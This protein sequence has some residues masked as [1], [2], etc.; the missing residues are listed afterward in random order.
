MRHKS[1]Q[2]SRRGSCA[3]WLGS[4]AVRSTM[5]ASTTNASWHKTA[6][7][8]GTVELAVQ[9]RSGQR[10]SLCLLSSKSGTGK[11]LFAI[12]PHCLLV[13]A[14]Y[15]PYDILCYVPAANEESWPSPIAN[16]FQHELM[17]NECSTME[18]APASLN[19]PMFSIL[20]EDGVAPLVEV[21][22][23]QVHDSA[24]RTHT[25]CTSTRVR[26]PELASSMNDTGG[27]FENIVTSTTDLDLIFLGKSLTRQ[28]D[29]GQGHATGQPC[30]IALPPGFRAAH[31]G[32]STP[33]NRVDFPLVAAKSMYMSC[34][35]GGAPHLSSVK[36]DDNF[37]LFHD[38]LKNK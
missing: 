16:H 36:T 3:R 27:F 2:S 26:R 12:S 33:S 30:G 11:M 14:L 25:P 32:L 15:N 29:G 1:L 20:A 18:V 8:S 34:T 31:R 38:L 13:A 21:Y 22:A 5:E 35:R 19:P 28:R 37:I 17:A 6:M 9:R 4:S 10:G 24:R 7:S 23:Q